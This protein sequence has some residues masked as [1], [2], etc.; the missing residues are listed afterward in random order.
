VARRLLDDAGV[1]GKQI[2]DSYILAQV[3]SLRERHFQVLEGLEGAKNRRCCS[4]MPL[5]HDGVGLGA[6]IVV[7]V[8]GAED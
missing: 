4:G 2:L 7:G 6:A 1:P 8:W 5:S 3:R